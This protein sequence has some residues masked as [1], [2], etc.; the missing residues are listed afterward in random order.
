M[1]VNDLDSGTRYEVKLVS[2]TGTGESSLETESDMQ[3]I[4]TLGAGLYFLSVFNE[5]YF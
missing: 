2:T 5:K 3:I 1:L 4:K